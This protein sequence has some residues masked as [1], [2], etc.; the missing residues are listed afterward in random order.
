MMERSSLRALQIYQFHYLPITSSILFSDELNEANAY[1][2]MAVRQTD[3]LGSS[4]TPQVG[5]DE[6]L[7]N[8]ALRIISQS[9]FL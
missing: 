4:T 2:T 7:H 6:Q 9:D 3:D 5:P 8:R 1:S